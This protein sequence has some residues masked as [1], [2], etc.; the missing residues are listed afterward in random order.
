[1]IES[2]LEKDSTGTLVPVGSRFIV[3]VSKSTADTAVSA[4]G[5]PDIRIPM[6]VRTGGS[7]CDPDS[8]VQPIRAVSSLFPV[9]GGG[10]EPFQLSFPPQA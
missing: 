10:I 9:E 4:R 6:S 2:I 3:G 7:L 5:C 8:I 1:M